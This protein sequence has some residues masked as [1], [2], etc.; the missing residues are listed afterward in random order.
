MRQD[1]A[2]ICQLPTHP[3][4]GDGNASVPQG[5]RLAQHDL[6]CVYTTLQPA[7]NPSPVS[8][9]HNRSNKVCLPPSF[10]S[11]GTDA[12]SRWGGGGDAFPAIALSVTG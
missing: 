7:M 11:G 2:V 10:Q 8:E 12:Q 9:P 4:T 1:S 6:L 5:F 3:A